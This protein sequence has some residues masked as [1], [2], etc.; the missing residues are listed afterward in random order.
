MWA[1][2]AAGQIWRAALVVFLL[3][4]PAEAAIV[5]TPGCSVVFQDDFE[6]GNLATYEGSWSGTRPVVVMANAIA[7]RFSM[8]S[9]FPTPNDVAKYLPPQSRLRLTVKVDL[10]TVTAANPSGAPTILTLTSRSAGFDPL[11]MYVSTTALGTPGLAFN[12]RVYR[13][14]SS[15]EVGRY[16]TLPTRAT[17]RIDW[18]R[19]TGPGTGIVRVY[20]DGGLLWTSRATGDTR[21]TVDSIYLGNLGSDGLASGTVLMD[22]VL[23]E[24]CPGVDGGAP[25]ADGG[26]TAD[27]GAAAVPDAAPAEP[28][29]T[30]VDRGPRVVPLPDAAPED[31]ASAPP[32]D[33]PMGPNAAD[34]LPDAVDAAASSVDAASANDGSASMKTGQVRLNVGCACT[35][36]RRSEGLGA[37]GGA[38]DCCPGGPAPSALNQGRRHLAS[39]RCDAWAPRR[40]WPKPTPPQVEAAIAQLRKALQSAEGRAVDPLTAP[41]AD[42]ERGRDQAPRGSSSPTL[43]SNR[44]NTA[45][46][47]AFYRPPL[48]PPDGVLA[49][50]LRARRTGIRSRRAAPYAARAALDQQ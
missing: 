30:A 47:R 33:G 34:A 38:R 19:A 25:M 23:V 14:A 45:G 35:V 43:T 28:D 46:L 20:V 8:S 4:A 29:V 2:M 18:E 5:P 11:W 48:C 7:D 21:T 6:S 44:R 16:M 22:D 24:T 27:D 49:S 42:I 13:N 32:D 3:E 40:P 15:F 1:G 17:I 39:R 31:A 37:F 36:G 12:T 26:P 50:P 41:W 9:G 10:R